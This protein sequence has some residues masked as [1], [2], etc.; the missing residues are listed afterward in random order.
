MGVTRQIIGSFEE[1]GKDVVKQTASVPKDI[2]GKALESLGGSSQTQK[3]Q[4]SPVSQVS[5][6][7]K[8]E[9]NPLDKMDQAKDLK[10]K[11]AIARAALEYLAKKIPKVPGVRE[12][13]EAEEQKKQEA[14]KREQA[15]IEKMKLKEPT[16]APKRGNLWG[17]TKQKAGSETSRNVRQD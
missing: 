7:Q 9:P 12:R 5:E 2:A 1:I 4:T 13:L 8:S 17:I 10:T 14:G 3:G 16:T 15:E 6:T 11:Q